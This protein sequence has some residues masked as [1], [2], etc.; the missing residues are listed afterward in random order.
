MDQRNKS[1]TGLK[2]MN[3]LF[4][5]PVF[6]LLVPKSL[7][8]TLWKAYIEKRILE[9]YEN[10]TDPEIIDI[11]KNIKSNGLEII[12]TS[13]TKKYDADDIVVFN[14]PD[15]NLK[16]VNYKKDKRL[17]FKKKWSKRRIQKAL[18]ELYIEQDLNSPH[19]YLTSNFDVDHNTIVADIGCA[20]ANFSLDIIDRVKHIYLFEGER[21]WSEP[22]LATFQAYKDKVTLINKRFSTEDTANSIDGKKFLK[23]KNINFFKIDVDGAEEEVMSTI[24]DTLNHAKQMKVALCT[25]HAQEDFATYSNKLKTLNFEVSS[26]NGYIIFLW[27]KSL[28]PPYLRRG[29]LRAQKR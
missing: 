26:S 9:W 21:T 14:D 2:F 20:E 12:S 3:T 6:R 15:K 27:D 29:L 11:I 25:Y 1:K 22:L 28:G 4:K 18:N 16:Y 23:D 24:A 5:N 19:R 13:L 17:Y 8:T 7:R 10:S